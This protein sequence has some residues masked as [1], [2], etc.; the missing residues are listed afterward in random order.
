MSWIAAVKE[1]NA[2]REAW[3]VPKKGT[4]EYD[5]VR[6]IQTK[7]AASAPKPAEEAAPRAA[8]VA[9]PKKED[10]GSLVPAAVEIRPEP[11][12]PRGPGRRKVETKDVPMLAHEQAAAPAKRRVVMLDEDEYER[13]VKPAAPVTTAP[14]PERKALSV[15]EHQSARQQKRDNK[16]KVAELRFKAAQAKIN[17]NREEANRLT[18]EMQALKKA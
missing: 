9:R 12:K 10:T 18:M 8:R 7:L 5:A 3:S 2:T 11:S 17:G 16:L 15:A 13:L 14:A 4:A 1:W 6:Q